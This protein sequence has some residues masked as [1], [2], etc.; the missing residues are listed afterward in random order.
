MKPFDAVY[1]ERSRRTQDKLRGIQDHSQRGAMNGKQAQKDKNLIHHS[2]FIVLTLPPDCLG[3]TKLMEL[4]RAQAALKAAKLCLEQRLFDSAANR[5]YFATFQAAICAL[6]SQGI[7]RKEWTHK[8]VHSDFVLLF[9]R[10][11]KVV[12]ASFVSA[13]PSLMQL[14]H[15]GDY[16]QPGVSQRQAERAVLLAQEF[17]ELLIKEVFS[18]P[19]TEKS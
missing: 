13:L 19:E 9:V 16:Q 5:A 18:A 10:R 12:P 4:E 2:S 7:K 3:A 14:R 17:V 11:R 1:P 8:G 15:I 6:E